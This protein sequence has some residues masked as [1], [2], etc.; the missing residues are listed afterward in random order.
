M[1]ELLFSNLRALLDKAAAAKAQAD[2][3]EAA[4]EDARVDLA[5]AQVSSRHQTASLPST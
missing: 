5:V 4:A 3:A 1:A 2:A